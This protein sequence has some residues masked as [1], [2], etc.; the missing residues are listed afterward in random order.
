MDKYDKVTKS[1][2]L[3]LQGAEYDT[4]LLGL[5]GTKLTWRNNEFAYDPVIQFEPYFTDDNP[6]IPSAVMF[7]LASGG[8][9][10]DKKVERWQYW[11]DKVWVTFE[12]GQPVDGDTH[13]Y[14]EI[15]IVW[16]YRELPREGFMDADIDRGLMYANRELNYLQLQGD[17]NIGFRSFGEMWIAGVDAK[18]LKRSQAVIHTLPEGATMGTTAPEDTIASVKDWIM[19]IYKFVAMN[20]HCS[21]D[22]VEGAILA[23]GVALAERNR[24]LNEDRSS[25]VEKWR[26]L[27]HDIYRIERKMALK[28]VGLKLPEEF[29]VDF[30]ESIDEQLT[31]EQ[32]I[33]KDT[34]DLE[35][36]LITYAQI[37]MRDNPDKYPTE[38]DAQSFIDG[39]K[40]VNQPASKLELALNEAVTL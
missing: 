15:P 28:E 33:A 17:A 6:F 24:E 7:P 30:S 8:S 35:H 29:S 2:N 13:G 11:D 32:Q 20:H 14:G 22:F 27:E 37:L 31:P 1:K 34:W 26:L 21:T 25:D 23:S 36:N 39:N 4:N 5:V 10:A 40:L 38:E 19:Q 3:R 9:R 18:E 16:S 12:D